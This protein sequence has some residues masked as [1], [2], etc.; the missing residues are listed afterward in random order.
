MGFEARSLSLPSRWRFWTTKY[1]AKG[2]L[3]LA[4]G[5]TTSAWLVVP[6]EVRVTLCGAPVTTCGVIQSSIHL[7]KALWS[8]QLAS[9]M[10]SSPT[11][12]SGPTRVVVV[13]VVG[14]PQGV[15]GLVDDH[16]LVVDAVGRAAAVLALPLPRVRG[17]RL[18]VEGRGGEVQLVW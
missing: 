16:D 12:P 9:I 1:S 14:Q 4:P 6:E 2:L 3:A 17:Q 5:M 10:S 18:A 8:P 7:L 11:P 15:A 13:V